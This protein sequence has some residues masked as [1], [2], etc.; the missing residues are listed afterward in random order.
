MSRLVR[1]HTDDILEALSLVLDLSKAS[2]KVQQV[3]VLEWCLLAG[4]PQ[5]RFSVFSSGFVAH[6]R[7]VFF[8]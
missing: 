8:F 2:E 4:I 7:R 6:L 3:V 1:S 5:N